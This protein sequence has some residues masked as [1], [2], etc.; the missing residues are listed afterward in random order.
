MRGAVAPAWGPPGVV[1]GLNRR[2]TWCNARLDVATPRGT[3]RAVHAGH[4]FLMHLGMALSLF[5]PKKV[6]Q[7]PGQSRQ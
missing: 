7:P 4:S 6:T 3:D 5:L 2:P 1:Q